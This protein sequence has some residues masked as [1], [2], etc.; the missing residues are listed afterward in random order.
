MFGF[1][2]FSN[3]I[4]LQFTS[5]SE[6]AAFE[7]AKKAKGELIIHLPANFTITP[8][9]P[10]GIAKIQDRYRFQFLIKGKPILG[11]SAA[12]LKLQEMPQPKGVHLLIDVD[13]LST[14]S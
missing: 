7:A 8:I 14:F 13:P 1:P 6:K 9:V 3:I 5:E 11:A 12:V 2:P 4:K 10:S